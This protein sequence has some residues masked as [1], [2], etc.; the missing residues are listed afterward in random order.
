MLRNLH[1]KWY[2]QQWTILISHIKISNKKTE[3]KF[4]FVHSLIEIF[5]DY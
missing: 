5:H 3:G 4:D 1:Q 2:K